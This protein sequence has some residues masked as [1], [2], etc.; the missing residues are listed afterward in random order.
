MANDI[1]WDTPASVAVKVAAWFVDKLAPAWAVQLA[2]SEPGAIVTD[3]GTDAAELLLTKNTVVPPAGAAFVSTTVHIVEPPEGI[4]EALHENAESCGGGSTVKDTVWDIPLKMAVTMAVCV[5]VTALAVALNAAVLEPAPTL[6]EAGTETLASLLVRL[7]VAM[8]PLGTGLLSVTV[9]AKV[10]SPVSDTGLQFNPL[11]A[12]PTVAKIIPP[13]PET[14]TG[15]PAGEAANELVMPTVV[16]L[17][18]GETE[19]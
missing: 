7:T 11:S 2:V 15:L 3:A 19:A 5:A 18:V 1:V 16:L 14:V 6:T 9:Q 10:P 12:G 8:P 13:V 17:T 4:N